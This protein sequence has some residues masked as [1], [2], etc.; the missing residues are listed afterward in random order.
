MKKQI[1]ENLIKKTRDD[2]NKIAHHFASTR[3]YVWKDI[4]AVTNNFDLS[5]KNVLDLGCGNGRLYDYLT[6]KGAKYT[7][8]DLGDNLIKIANEKHPEG[9]FTQGDLLET[10]FKDNEFDYVYCIATLHHIPSKEKRNA[11]IQEIYRIL[12]PGGK[13][14]ITNWYFWNKPKYLKMILD[15][16]LQNNNLP[17]GD[18]FMPWKSTHKN[19]LAERYFH[20]WTKHETISILKKNG[21]SDIKIH[22]Q[23]A[24]EKDLPKYN[25]VTTAT[26]NS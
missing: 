19:T 17:I 13:I 23:D 4:D 9:R 1:S 5:S 6:K 16:A 25:I 15:S 8:L 20:A 21:F 7:G 26:K 10:P 14:L 18:F 12:K 24:S 22:Y 11:A 2:Y 3:K